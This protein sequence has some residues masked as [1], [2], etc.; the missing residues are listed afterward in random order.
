MIYMLFKLTAR[1][2]ENTDVNYSECFPHYKICVQLI[3]QKHYTTIFF[4]IK[5]ASRFKVITTTLLK[6]GNASLGEYFTFRV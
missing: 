4:L 3:S 6:C 2:I 5:H 1:A